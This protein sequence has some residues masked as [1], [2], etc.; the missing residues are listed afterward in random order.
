MPSL[1]ITVHRWLGVTLC[2]FMAAWFASGAVLIYVP[3]PSL[4]PSERLERAS[5]V[6]PSTVKLTPTGAIRAS[7]LVQPIDSIRLV[8]RDA[9]PLY[10]LKGRGQAVTA[11]WAD[12]GSPA[13]LQLEDEARQ[14]A[15]LFSGARVRRIEGPIDY[16]QW[17]VHQ[18]FDTGRPYLRVSI[19]DAAGTVLYVSQATGEVQQRTTRSQRGWNYVGAVVHWIYPTALRKHWAAWD[20]V[21]WW[22]S[23][24]GIAVV[25]IGIVL[26]FDHM[27]VALRSKKI[28]FSLF[29]GWMKWHH[30]F[31]LG[32][33]LFVL[34]WIFSGW[35]SMDHG[36]LFST[37]DPTDQQVDRFNG[38]G[39][40][41][42]GQQVRLQA[43]MRLGPFR[44]LEIRSIAGTPIMIARGHSEQHIYSIATGKPFAGA[45]LPISLVGAAV[46]AAWPEFNVQSIEEVMAEDVYRKVRQNELPVS[47]IRVKL[48]DPGNTWVHVDAATG[49]ILSVMDRSR[50]V[51]RWLYNGLHSLD[52]PGLID[53]RPLWDI[54]ILTLLAIGFTFSITGVYLGL[55]R[56]KKTLAIDAGEV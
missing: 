32:V 53:R 40:A 38:I 39:L 9:R 45:V 42:A 29:R 27:I 5:E 49:Q 33:G 7:G 12:D 28:E 15:S 20:L 30:V 51:Y 8:A 43:I 1:F 19:D 22:L 21:V 50:R 25:I 2:L 17:I 16:D 23:L 4:T 3:F 24:A 48:D 14:V 55:R 47:S 35:L 52:F 46:Q 18:G 6:E 34:T 56:L 10:V 36:R 37:P 11:V 54:V 31:G 26:G 41:E 44:E 13:A